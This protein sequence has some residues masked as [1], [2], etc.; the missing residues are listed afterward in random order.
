MEQN[1]QR[2]KAGDNQHMRS[3]HGATT[4]LKDLGIPRYGLALIEAR[5]MSA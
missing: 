3:S 5:R 1:G 2:A 4:T